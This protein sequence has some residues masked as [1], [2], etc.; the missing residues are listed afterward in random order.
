MKRIVTLLM[1]ICL[2]NVASFAQKKYEMVVEKTDGTETFF[3][4]ED[5]KRTY[6]RERIEE[7]NGG[8]EEIPSYTSCPDGNHPHWV[9]L[10]LPSGTKW[11]CCNVGASSPEEYGSYL[12]LDEAPLYNSPSLAQIV[13][14]LINTTSVWTTLNGVNGRRFSGSNGGSVF[15]P[16]AGYR[17]YRGGELYYVAVGRDGSYRSST[18][19]DDAAGWYELIFD[20]DGAR[21]GLR[22]AYRTVGIPVRPVR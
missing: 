22:D 1:A 17:Y 16:A 7:D 15:L 9:D 5:V 20:S 4:V 12:S 6:F 3:N 11:C 13:E 18:P 10:G 14:F 8:G 2:Y 19:T 21:R